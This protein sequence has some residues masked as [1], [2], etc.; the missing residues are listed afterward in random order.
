MHIYMYIYTDDARRSVT[1][2][3]GT[4]SGSGSGE[5]L[6][7]RQYEAGS[8][9]GEW[10]EEMQYEAILRGHEAAVTCMSVRGD[11]SGLVSGGVDEQVHVFEFGRMHRDSLRSLHSFEPQA[12][13]L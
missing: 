11:R 1:G 2:G 7:E 10:L 13:V 12:S 3:A 4:G 8:G 6:R 9:S 5:Y